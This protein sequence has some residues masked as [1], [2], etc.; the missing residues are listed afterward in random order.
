L[1]TILLGQELA[2][3]DH[4]G[5]KLYYSKRYDEFL[6]SY[7][8]CSEEFICTTCFEQENKI[9]KGYTRFDSL[10]VCIDHYSETKKLNDKL[11]SIFENNPNVTVITDL[12]L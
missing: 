3:K 1:S 4:Y 7:Q 11:R 6:K 12:G 2:T 9:T 5:Q 8:L 10:V